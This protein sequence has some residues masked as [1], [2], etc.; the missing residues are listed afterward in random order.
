MNKRILTLI[1]TLVVIVE[2]GLF[3][4]TMPA[5]TTTET[6]YDPVTSEN[7]FAG[8]QTIEKTNPDL[9]K[10]NTIY[11]TVIGATLVLGVIG[12]AVVPKSAADSD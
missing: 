4:F 2:L 8:A 6:T 11:L 5:S 12:V 3:I 7:R 10:H 1:L 9:T